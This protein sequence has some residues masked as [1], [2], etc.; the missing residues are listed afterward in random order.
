MS[1]YNTTGEEIKVLSK[2]IKLSGDFTVNWNGTDKN[3]YPVTTGVYF[4]VVKS[5]EYRFCNKLLLIK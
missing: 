1:N 2:G 5:N 3:N 4:V